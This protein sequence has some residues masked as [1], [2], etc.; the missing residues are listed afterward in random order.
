MG[1]VIVFATV[2]AGCPAPSDPAQ[3]VSDTSVTQT[4]GD[5][6]S[7][8]TTGTTSETSSGSTSS[9]SITSTTSGTDTA[10]ASETDEEVIPAP[11]APDPTAIPGV[12]FV[13]RIDG[14]DPA[15]YRF[16][17]S[18]SGFLAAFN[19]TSASVELS[20]SGQNQFTVLVD[21]VLQPT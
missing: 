6:G 19:G 20:D 3:D 10:D 17:W 16:A 15:G 5:S 7:S 9:S 21:G 18:G 11:P 2:L 12:R 8:T 1:C 13:G 4:N 14:T